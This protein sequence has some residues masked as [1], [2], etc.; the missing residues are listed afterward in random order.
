MDA[1]GQ[2]PGRQPSTGSGTS[3]GTT[4]GASGTADSRYGLFLFFLFT[5]CRKLSLVA[6]MKR[7]S[8]C[9]GKFENLAPD[10]TFRALFIPLLVRTSIIDC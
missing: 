2:L 4:G 3:L 8:V 9:R 5:F 7:L 6:Y 10:L 1:V